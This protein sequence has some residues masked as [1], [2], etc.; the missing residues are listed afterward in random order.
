MTAC[1]YCLRLIEDGL[2][3]CPFCGG[4]QTPPPETSG[5]ERKNVWTSIFLN[6]IIVT[7]VVACSLIG[8]LWY[9]RQTYSNNLGNHEETTASKS[10]HDIR[11]A[12]SQ[13]ALTSGDQYPSSLGTLGDQTAQPLQQARTESYDVTYT[14][15]SSREDRAITG[16]E[17]WANPRKPSHRSFYIDESGILRATQENR[18][19]NDTDPP[20]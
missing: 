5:L 16:F 10:L 14:P 11:T 8:L 4:D 9:A 6:L 18:P 12:L 1:W 7:V 15:K 3:I 19:A 20:I 17:L 13:Y 2:K